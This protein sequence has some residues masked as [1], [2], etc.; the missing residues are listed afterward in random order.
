MRLMVPAAS[1]SMPDTVAAMSQ[2]LGQLADT[3]AGLLRGR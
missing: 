1:E 2:A 3:M